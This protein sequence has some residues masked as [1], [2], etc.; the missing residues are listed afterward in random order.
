LEAGLHH[1]RADDLKCR[2]TAHAL[3]EPDDRR[4]RSPFRRLSAHRLRHLQPEG[5]SDAERKNE[6]D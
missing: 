6:P 2:I 4:Y 5:E 3:Y 1:T